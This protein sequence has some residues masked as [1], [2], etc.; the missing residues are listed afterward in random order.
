MSAF[1]AAIPSPPVTLTLDALSPP[2][3]WALRFLTMTLRLTASG[4]LFLGADRDSGVPRESD[5][6]AVLVSALDRP[7]MNARPAAAPAM[8]VPPRRTAPR[9][10]AAAMAI[11]VAEVLMLICFPGR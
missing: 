6:L 1:G 3:F 5:I 9:S 11:G 7:R 8:P 4:A 2:T 10:R